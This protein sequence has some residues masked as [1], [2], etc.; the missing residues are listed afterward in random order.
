MKKNTV[1][2]V[3]IVLIAVSFIAYKQITKSDPN[4]YLEL[5]MQKI[6]KCLNSE[7]KSPHTCSTT[8]I[9]NRDVARCS[10]G[11]TKF[12]FEIKNMGENMSTVLALNG[13]ARQLSSP[14]KITRCAIL[15]SEDYE[16]ANKV[17]PMT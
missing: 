9:D 16:F 17:I 2:I 8:K 10:I 1:V 12:V 6:E 5:G 14:Y 3:F 15:E 4:K 11:Q 13:K 7:Y